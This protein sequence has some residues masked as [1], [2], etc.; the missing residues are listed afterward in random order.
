MTMKRFL[1]FAVCAGSCTALPAW[2]QIDPLLPLKSVRPNVIVALDLSSRMQR[3]PA[4]E[5]YLDPRVFRRLGAAFEA[6]LGI[7]PQEADRE[8]RRRYLGLAW[9]DPGDVPRATCDEVRAVGDRAA[10]FGEVDARTRFGRAAAAILRAIEGNGATIRFGLVTTRQAAPAV[11]L[12]EAPSVLAVRPQAGAPTDT[13]L[14]SQWFSGFP[15]VAGPGG[16]ASSA[17]AS[18]KADD[19]GGHV[20]LRG[21]LSRAPGT[22]GAFLPAGLDA[23]TAIDAPLAQLVDDVRAEA[24]RLAASDDSCRNTVVVIVTA[25]GDPAVGVSGLEDRAASLLDVRGRRVAVHVVAIAPPAADAEQLRR[26]AVRTGGRYVEVGAAAVDAT[27]SSETVPGLVAAINFACSHALEAPADFNTA[28]TAVQPFGRPSYVATTGP[29]VGTLNL[30][31]AV[32]SA[33]TLLPGTSV[34]GR[35]GELVSQPSNV[36]VTAGYDLPGF[37]GRL[38]AFRVYRPVEDE[39]RPTGYRFTADGTRIWTA[40][41]PPGSRRNVFTVLPGAG[42]VPFQ[43]ASAG[44]L[45]PYLRVRDPAALIEAVR[46]LPIGPILC[47]TPALLEPPSGRVADLDYP[48]FVA[49]NSGRRSLVFV[50]ADDGMMHAF[51][52]RTG[53]EVWA[54]IPFNLLPR[55][56]R[57]VEGRPIDAFPYFV[58]GS[59]RLADVKV[60]GAWRTYLFFGEGPGGTF[61]QAFDVTLDGVAGAVPP[62]DDRLTALLGWF[63]DSG[64]VPFRW[65]FPRYAVFDAALPPDGDIMASATPIEK[66]VGETWATPVVGRLG[67]AGPFV[68]V[69]GSGRLSAS[70]EQ[71]PGRGGARAGTSLY[72]IEVPTGLPLD[73]RDVGSDGAAEDDRVGP[74]SGGLKNALQADPL[75]VVDE[76]TRVVTSVYAGDL[77]GRLWRFDLAQSGAPGFVAGPRLLFD[78]GREQPLFGSVARLAGSGGQGFLFFAT[79]SDL[80]PRRGGPAAFKLVGLAESSAGVIRQFQRS[81]R[82][83][84]ADGVDESVAGAPVVAGGVV[85]FAT[86]GTRAMGACEPAEAVLYGL[87]VT[88]GVAYDTNGDH[89]R[90]SRDDPA[91]SRLRAGRSGAPIVADRHLFVSSGDRVQVFGD[92]DGFAAGQGVGGLRVVSW[93]ELR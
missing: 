20:V 39:N 32:D 87:N 43:A 91:V 85:F 60:D 45:A 78:A 83:A 14:P 37:T 24:D 30:E 73:V 66:S 9:R 57:L 17:G 42:V 56:S 55:L 62:D 13:G 25:G 53:L 34:F 59:P 16:A 15:K 92:P 76:R 18:V 35:N 61:Y 23:T 64:H 1:L 80:L 38:S 93:R 54:L 3:D 29:V 74:I 4:D 6:S 77:D 65:S 84:A 48:A 58:G 44:S 22:V 47:S 86:T 10:A 51:D 11:D 50:G 31:G 70:A 28:P 33:G 63:A 12:S 89:R 72:L 27:P 71:R 67:R 49:A 90:D 26:I 82:T 75:A 8:Y 68:V 69:T 52:A 41:A 36:L 5:G 7:G 19:P 88:G 81:L 21:L 46:D 79:G 40:A 2:S